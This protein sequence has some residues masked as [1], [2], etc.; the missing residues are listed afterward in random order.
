VLRYNARFV[1]TKEK[2]AAGAPERWS[3]EE[4]S[5]PREVR[6]GYIVTPRFVKGAKDGVSWSV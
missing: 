6:R 1:T 4:K 3:A 2:K 5:L